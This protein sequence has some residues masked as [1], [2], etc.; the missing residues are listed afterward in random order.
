MLSKYEDDK[1]TKGRDQENQPSLGNK[2]PLNLNKSGINPAKSF[3]QFDS[4]RPSMAN[5]GQRVAKDHGMN[6]E[7]KYNANNSSFVS[8]LTETNLRVR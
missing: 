3:A 1:L 2:S 8:P 5:F 7:S 4:N 6:E